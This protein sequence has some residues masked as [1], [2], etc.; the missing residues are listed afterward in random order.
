ME[1]LE[2][3]TRIGCK[4]ACKYC[5]QSRLIKRY[6]SRSGDLLMSFDLFKRCL[7]HTPRRVQIIFCGMCEPWLNPDCIEMVKF[8]FERGHRVAIETTL[9]GVT[10]ADIEKLGELQFEFIALHLACGE[11]LEQIKVNKQYLEMLQAVASGRLPAKQ[12]FFHYYGASLH[13]E[14]QKLGIKAS[15]ISLMSRAN[16]L[17]MQG[18]AQMTKRKGTI[19]CRRKMRYNVLMP[20]GDVLLCSHDYDMRH[21]LGN[22]LTGSYESLF[23]G[24]EYQKVLEGLTDDKAE[25]LCRYCENHAYQ[26]KAL[27]R[28]VEACGKALRRI[29]SR[30]GI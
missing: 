25:I 3:T 7:E 17:G 1:V 21:I 22:L 18:V 14:I 16:N 30:A 24:E 5:P 11:G 6:K 29:R 4:V 23:T 9:V 15:R 26:T 13:P 8:A 28:L 2:I 27:P 12:M 20:N 10:P 19:G